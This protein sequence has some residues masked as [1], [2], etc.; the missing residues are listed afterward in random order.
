MADV[1][2]NFGDSVAAIVITDNLGFLGILIFLK[3][4]ENLGNFIVIEPETVSRVE[5]VA[6]K[7]RVRRGWGGLRSF[8]CGNLAE[9]V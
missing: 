2:D 7:V 5:D 4:G 3:L 9:L 6:G 1:L 8:D